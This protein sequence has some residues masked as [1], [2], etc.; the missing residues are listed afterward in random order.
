LA[1]DVLTQALERGDARVAQWVLEHAVI[2]LRKT[3]DAEEKSARM[4]D[5]EARAELIRRI[6]SL[7]AQTG[8]TETDSGPVAGSG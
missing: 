5:E 4:K 7:A 3:D 1:I 6:D 2:R 8:A